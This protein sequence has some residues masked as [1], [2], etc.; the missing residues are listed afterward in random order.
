MENYFNT[1]SMC[2]ARKGLRGFDPVPE[3]EPYQY[4][5]APCMSRLKH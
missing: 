5:N 2:W 1:L 4:V 3:T